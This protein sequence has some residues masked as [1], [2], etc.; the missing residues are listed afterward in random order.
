MLLAPE[1]WL[2]TAT[3]EDSLQLQRLI[4]SSLAMRISRGEI[5]NGETIKAREER[6]SKWVGVIPGG[7]SLGNHEVTPGIRR[8]YG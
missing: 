6:E 2:A 4:G 5:Q 1:E 8:D 7:G 3:S